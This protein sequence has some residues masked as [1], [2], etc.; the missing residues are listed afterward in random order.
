MHIFKYLSQPFPVTLNKWKVILGVSLFIGVFMLIFQPFG[1]QEYQHNQKALILSG[2]GI[3][4]FLVLIIDMFFIQMIFPGLFE[5][6]SWTVLK[7]IIWLAWI[8]FSIGLGNLVYSVYVF[9]FSAGI[10]TLFWVFQLFTLVIGLIPVILITMIQQ[11]YLLKR[12]VKNAQIIESSLSLHR[13]SS[14]PMVTIIA[15]NGKDEFTSSPSDILF[16]ESTG[17][18]ISILY[19]D[20]GKTKRLVLRNTLK[21]A[22]LQLDQSTMLFRCHR[23]YIVNLEKIEKI[24]GNSQGYRLILTGYPDEIPVSRNYIQNFREKVDSLGR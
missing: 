19:L 20:N 5:E 6:K 15:E 1:L 18:Y 24:K 21:N 7:Q 12:N 10:F 8:L 16:L 23:A 22:E 17:N 3:V 11:N 2:Y 14:F 9:Q 4:T 13:T